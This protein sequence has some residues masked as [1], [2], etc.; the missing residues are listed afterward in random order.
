MVRDRT[1][2]EVIKVKRGPKAGALTDRPGVCNKRKRTRSPRA[3]RASPTR[4]QQD[5]GPLHAEEK[6]TPEA[7]S[8]NALIMDFQTRY[9]ACGTVMAVQAD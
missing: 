4:T 9:P 6:A 1:S 7:G 5:G 2:K 8:P 3:Q